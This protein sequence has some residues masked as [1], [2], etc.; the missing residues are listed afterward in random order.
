[1]LSCNVIKPHLKTIK[2]RFLHAIQPFHFVA[3]ILHPTFRGAQL[4]HSQREEANQWI[5]AQHPEFLPLF[6][7]FDTQSAP[8]PQSFSSE[9]MLKQLPILWWKA[10]LKN[11]KVEV[12]HKFSS[13][14][15]RL[16][17]APASSASIERMFSNFGYIHNKL[18]NRLGG[19]T[20]AKLV[21]CYH[22]LCGN[23]ESEED[24]HSDDRVSFP[25][26]SGMNEETEEPMHV[27]PEDESSETDS[28]DWSDWMTIE[29]GRL[30]ARGT[31][32]ELWNNMNFAV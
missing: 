29:C 26:T 30:A 31:D 20:A 18:C 12:H 27:L 13:L 1:M 5:V 19:Q 9:A 21:F 14:A 24:T 11:S 3:Y 10:V 2:A 7:A 22:M 32:I 17:S 6:I 28:D 25:S 4:I 15:V 16:L 8:F 23:Y